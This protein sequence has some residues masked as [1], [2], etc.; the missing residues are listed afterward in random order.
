[1]ASAWHDANADVCAEPNEKRQPTLRPIG[2]RCLL[3]ALI[4]VADSRLRVRAK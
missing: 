4:F 3:L 1:M 2:N